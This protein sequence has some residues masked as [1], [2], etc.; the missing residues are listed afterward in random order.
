MEQKIINLNTDTFFD[1]NKIER[2]KIINYYKLHIKKF[3]FNFYGK[4]NFA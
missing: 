2:S 3:N 1:L 4:E